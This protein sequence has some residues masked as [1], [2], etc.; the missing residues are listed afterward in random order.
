MPRAGTLASDDSLTGA[1]EAHAGEAVEQEAAHFVA[2]VAAIGTGAVLGQGGT[3]QR[4]KPEGD[5]PRDADN[6]GEM[7][8]GEGEREGERRSEDSFAGALPYPSDV[9]LKAKYVKDNVDANANALGGREDPAAKVT[10][11]S[12]E[13]AVWERMRPVMRVLADVVDGWERVA[14]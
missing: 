12:V 13:G 8:V 9:A 5:V 1:P 7:E 6:A 10:K 4:K 2:S 3:P 11:R 14:K